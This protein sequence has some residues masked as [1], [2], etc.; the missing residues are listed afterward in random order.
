MCGS[1]WR[2]EFGD[3]QYYTCVWN[4]HVLSPELFCLYRDR[5]VEGSRKLMETLATKLDLTK[6]DARLHVFMDRHI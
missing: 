1:E 2:G 6:R 5:E 3:S 4:G